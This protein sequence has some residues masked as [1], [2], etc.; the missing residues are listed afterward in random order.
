MSI[1][2]KNNRRRGLRKGPRKEEVKAMNPN[3]EPSIRELRGELT[4]ATLENTN[5]RQAYTTLKGQTRDQ[6]PSR[7]GSYGLLAAGLALVAGVAIGIFSDDLTSDN[8]PT[9]NYAALFDQTAQILYGRPAQTEAE[10]VETYNQVRFNI[11]PQ[12]GIREETITNYEPDLSDRIRNT[13]HQIT[14]H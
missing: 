13:T 3:P 2:Q 14:N 9:Q 7:F 10:M 12:D 8:D 11:L 4:R 1:A 5:L 6:P